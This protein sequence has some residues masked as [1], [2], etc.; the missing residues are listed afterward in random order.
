MRAI[1]HTDST[2]K[3]PQNSYRSSAQ[4]KM[5]PVDD[6]M[7]SSN[8]SDVRRSITGH[9]FPEHAAE[10]YDRIS[11]AR[12]FREGMAIKRERLA[13]SGE[14]SS[15][16]GEGQISCVVVARCL[17]LSTSHPCGFLTRGRPDL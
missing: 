10:Q 17:Y 14:T 12:P 11:I 13:A 1:A 8:S 7:R 5:P 9:D 4:A 15:E 16:T 3:I 6:R 2:A